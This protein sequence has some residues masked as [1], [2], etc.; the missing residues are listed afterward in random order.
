MGL[1]FR[2]P[3]IFLKGKDEDEDEDE[4]ATVGSCRSRV[5]CYEY[6]R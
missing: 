1:E 6:T 4:D 2:V 3:L 5:F